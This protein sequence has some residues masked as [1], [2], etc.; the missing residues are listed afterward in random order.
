VLQNLTSE[1]INY[2]KEKKNLLLG[3]EC[4]EQVINHIELGGSFN[5]TNKEASMGIDNCFSLI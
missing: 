5:E 3:K 4:F 1:K 2:V